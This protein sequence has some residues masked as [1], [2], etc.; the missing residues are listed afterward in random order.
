MGKETALRGTSEGE[1]PGLGARN[2]VWGEGE[3]EQRVTPCSLSDQPGKASEGKKENAV[4]GLVSV[5]S[6]DG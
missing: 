4:S 5:S 6:G 2:T 3:K 1:F